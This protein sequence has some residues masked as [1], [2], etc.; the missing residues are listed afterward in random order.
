MRFDCIC[1]DIIPQFNKD[2]RR[3]Y[4]VASFVWS[5]SRDSDKYSKMYFASTTVMMANS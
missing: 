1:V 5:F 2:S 3:M 4:R